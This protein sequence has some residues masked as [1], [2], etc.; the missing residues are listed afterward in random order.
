MNLMQMGYPIGGGF[1]QTTAGVTAGGGKYRL[2]KFS[3]ADRWSGMG[4][5]LGVGFAAGAHPGVYLEVDWKSFNRMLARNVGAMTIAAKKGI[6]DAGKQLYDKTKART[7]I[8]TGLARN[9]WE[10]RT[11]GLASKT[12]PYVEIA[13]QV[14]YTVQL[15][16]G[17]SSQAPQG[18]LRISM[19]EMSGVPKK[20]IAAQLLLEKKS[21]SSAAAT[22]MAGT[23]S[24]FK[25]TM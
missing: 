18:M 13:N 17:S 6:K 21:F 9:G 25:L 4:K 19:K 23:F 14:Y 15:E 20:Q 1:G 16:F 11:K 10:F 12:R 22:S 7:P 24:T 8:K 5:S 3:M 2:Q